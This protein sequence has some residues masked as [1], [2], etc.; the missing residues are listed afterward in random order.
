LKRSIALDRHCRRQRR[1]A[2]FMTAAAIA[3]AACG[4][5]PAPFVIVPVD[6]ST[7]VEV[8]TDSPIGRIALWVPE[9]VMSERGACAIYPQG[10][11]WRRV[12]QAWEQTIEMRHSYGPGNYRRV[13]DTLIDFV[14]IDVPVDS[15]VAWT[16]RLTPGP[17][18]LAFEIELQNVGDQPICRAGG[19]VCVKFLD[20]DW[21][22][23][24]TT[25]A[26]TANGMASLAE[27]G[28]GDGADPRF[29]AYLL[30]REEFDNPFYTAFW[31][32]NRRRLVRP[33]LVSEHR[34]A[35][36]RAVVSSEKAYFLHCNF[37]N[38]CTDVML[39]FGD[40]APGAT[41]TARGELR[42]IFGRAANVLRAKAETR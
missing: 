40:V 30:R 6:D 41:A 14:D 28:R 26:A 29:E 18:R 38:P 21:W 9:A 27:L 15:P 16:T 17:G 12:G 32:F 19:A 33:I 37:V 22:S 3:G 34:E 10:A 13:S 8:R 31:G 20:A 2:F 11:P 23:E 39:A 25:F 42:L 4:S 36:L 5:E 1:A 35:E 24:Q 7:R